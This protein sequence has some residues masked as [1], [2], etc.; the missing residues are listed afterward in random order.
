M[1]RDLVQ[2]AEREFGTSADSGA[3]QRMMAALSHQYG[4]ERVYIEKL[5]KLVA[6]VRMESI[7]TGLGA[8]VLA[9][10]TGLSVR[11]VRRIVRSR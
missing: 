2:L 8:T 11:H 5:P 3:V 6:Q 4:G 9:R 7:G 1:I 10:D